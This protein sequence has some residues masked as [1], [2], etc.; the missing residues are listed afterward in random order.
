MDVSAISAATARVPPATAP[1]EAIPTDQAAENREVVRAVR[2]LNGTEMFGDENE[3]TF[4]RDP[5]THRMVVRVVNRVTRELVSQIPA[6]YVLRLAE[7]LPKND[8]PKDQT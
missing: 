6:E 7:D 5:T 8:Q 4:Q 2:A 1:A 3:L